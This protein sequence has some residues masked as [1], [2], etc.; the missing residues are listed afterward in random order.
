MVTNISK[1]RVAL[2][3]A[4]AGI[5]ALAVAISAGI[6]S[7]PSGA[8]AGIASASSGGWVLKGSETHK[9]APD[10]PG[11]CYS[12]QEVTIAGLSATT[13]VRCTSTGPTYDVYQRSQHSWSAAPPERLAPGEVLRISSTTSVEGTFHTVGMGGGASTWVRI[14]LVPGGGPY[15][16]AGWANATEEN[17]TVS[18]DSEFSIPSG[19]EGGLML[20]TL[21]LQGVAGSG[22][23]TY[24]Y[25]WQGTASGAT[26]GPTGT[27]RI[28]PTETTAP[29]PTE[30]PWSCWGW[31]RRAS[32]LESY[33]GVSVAHAL[34]SG[35]RF[36]YFSGEVTV[37]PGHDLDDL[38]PASFDMVLDVGNHINTESDSCAVIGFGDMTTFVMNSFTRVILMAPPEKQ[39]KLSLLTGKLLVNL[40]KMWK[41]GSMDVTMNQA[42]AGIKGTNL[43]LEETGDESTIKVLEGNVEFTSLATGETVMV[44]AGETVSATAEGLSE[45]GTFD[46]EAESALWPLEGGDGLPALVIVAGVIVLVSLAGLIFA[47]QRKQGT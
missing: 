2:L 19:R 14:D 23:T 17:T 29:R 47:R 30:E 6:A 4:L 1:R 44:G 34:D 41:D 22:Q 40:K 20:V 42:V 8:G 31:P 46:V 45:K 27:G 36:T 3:P 16:G 25:E 24:T 21:R 32:L 33:F 15:P 9:E 37:A 12:G 18:A 28:D 10:H 38:R 7:T 13:Y 39:S 43:V 5:V 26:P 11:D 35:A